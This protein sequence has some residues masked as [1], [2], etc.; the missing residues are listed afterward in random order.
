MEDATQ[1]F[2]FAVEQTVP[3]DR[4]LRRKLQTFDN[5]WLQHLLA[6]TVTTLKGEIPDAGDSVAMDVKHLYAWVRENNPRES[7]KD[8]FCK[9]RQPRGDPDCRVGVKSSTNQQQPDGSC[10]QRRRNTCGA[11]ARA[12]PRPP[13]QTTGMW[14]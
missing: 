7:I 3:C 13:S 11:M 9:D 8:R 2:G 6:G 4:H 1:P 10:D 5:T 14:S 12:L